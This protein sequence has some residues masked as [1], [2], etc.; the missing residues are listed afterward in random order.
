MKKYFSKFKII[1]LILLLG[2]VVFFSLFD[3]NR[4]LNIK[5]D[6]RTISNLKSRFSTI[7]IALDDELK[8]QFD[9][10]TAISSYITDTNISLTQDNI[11]S[12]MKSYNDVNI[13]NLL[14]YVDTDGYGITSEGDTIDL[15]QREYFSE[16]LKNG[17]AMAFVESSI[18]NNK[19]KYILVI[20]VVKNGSP[21][22]VLVGVYDNELFMPAITN[23]IQYENNVYICDETGKIISSLV[24][25][26]NDIFTNIYDDT[27]VFNDPKV[28]TTIKDDIAGKI[29]NII[30]VGSR[31]ER[32]YVSYFTIEDTEWVIFTVM[33]NASVQQEYDEFDVLSVNPL[34]WIGLSF[35]VVA[36]SI[37]F[38]EHKKLLESESEKELLRQSKERYHLLDELTDSLS[39]EA[40][41][42]NDLMIFSNNYRLVFGY[43]PE[44][45]KF[46]DYLKENKIIC[47][48]DLKVVN[49]F[50]VQIKN[51][52][53]AHNIE[54]RIITKEGSMIWCKITGIPLKDSFGKV[55]GFIGKISNRD[56]QIKEIKYLKNEVEKDPLTK[57]HNRE[58]FEQKVDANISLLNNNG[59]C[60]FFMIDLDDFK[61]VNDLQGHIIGDQLLILIAEIMGKMFRKTD[62]IGRMGG[63]EFAVFMID[64]QSLDIVKEK[65]QDLLIAIAENTKAYCIDDRLSCS[66]GIAIT[67]KQNET[68]QELYKRADILL[69]QAKKAG[70]N[71]YQ[72]EDQAKSSNI[73]TQ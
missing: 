69:Y 18:I 38:I 24:I 7:E 32:K 70:K 23:M 55:I 66:I 33:P 29:D 41:F 13:S 39:F 28:L 52:T 63:D 40:D 10:L 30:V 21:V 65:A 61:Q 57:I 62:I 44:T 1:F 25:S 47:N 53:S 26:S 37:Y 12:L 19:G 17:K 58:S 67:S 42:I 5:F 45:N 59:I 71:Q 46:S 6:E 15:S 8:R 60:A 43:K 20:S 64:V 35:L 36:F 11:Q 9:A 49:D 31:A 27:G 50:I 48:D 54:C 72:I 56:E 16:C 34:V 14:I 4:K 68:F 22:G 51:G 73:L 3:Y 2:L